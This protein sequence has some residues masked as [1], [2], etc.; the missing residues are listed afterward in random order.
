MINQILDF[1]SNMQHPIIEKLLIQFFMVQAL[2][3]VLNAYYKHVKRIFI[4]KVSIGFVLALTQVLIMLIPA[5]IGSTPIDISTIVLLLTFGFFGNTQGLIVLG[6]TLITHFLMKPPLMWLGLIPYVVA[7]LIPHLLR[8]YVMDQK[9]KTLRA[10]VFVLAGLSNSLILL[11]IL[12]LIPD[13]RNHL[14]ET[15][16]TLLVMFPTIAFLN[17]IVMYDQRIQIYTMERL[18]QSEALQRASINAPHEME[19]YV[20]DRDYN[21]LSFNEF[22]AK[23]LRRFFNGTAKMGANFLSEIPNEKVRVRLEKMIAR[24]LNGEK[25]NVEIPLESI[26]GKF[27]HEFYA[28]IYRDTEII[29]VTIFSYEITERKKREANITYLSYHDALTNLYNRRYFDDYVDSLSKSDEEYVVVYADINGL[30]IMN[31]I[32]SHDVGDQL[33]ITVAQYIQKA[34]REHG[35]VSRTGGDEIITIVQKTSLPNVKQMVRELKAKLLEKKIENIELSVSFGVASTTPKRGLLETIVVAE[36]L[37]YKDKLDDMLRQRTNI[38]NAL[39]AKVQPIKMDEVSDPFLLD[40]AK[41]CGARLALSSGEVYYLNEL[42]RL[43]DISAL[44]VPED[45]FIAACNRDKETC[46]L[47]RK[48]LEIAYRMLISTDQYSVIASDIVAMNENYDGSGLPRGLKGAEIPLKSR[49]AKI[50]C[51]YGVLVTA[52]T[53]RKALSP[54]VALDQLMTKSGT[55]YD[56]NLLS[57]FT[58]LI[59]KQS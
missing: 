56:P 39:I 41:Q 13:V 37:M 9:K 55:L 6:A 20:V 3:L 30:K 17:A 43:R 23:N 12:L 2:A 10:F 7:S 53:N 34:F 59:N 38:V 28:P 24:A 57:I 4:F 36:D 31:D 15:L 58:E 29:G 49:I 1:F 45:V 35:V 51:A 40:L 25:F 16:F 22:H 48:R 5:Q 54:K 47:M 46:L 11:F 14:F 26:P 50:I 21:Y 42:I 32:F 8:K 52:T 44:A 27:I 19:I 33:I 18:A